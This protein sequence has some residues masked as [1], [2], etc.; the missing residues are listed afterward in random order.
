MDLVVCPDRHCRGLASQLLDE[1]EHLA[2]G[3]EGGKGRKA[4]DEMYL[5]IQK[6]NDVAS[7]MYTRRG[8]RVFDPVDKEMATFVKAQERLIMLRRSLQ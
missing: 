4:F 8:Y 5:C 3:V 2:G 7:D 1:A 6:A